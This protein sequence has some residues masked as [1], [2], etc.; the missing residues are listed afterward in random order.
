MYGGFTLDSAATVYIA[1]RGPSLQT[2]GATQNPLDAPG[3]RLYDAAGRDLLL[4]TS[5]GGQ[6]A[7]CLATNTT[8]IYYATVRGQA[9]DA[10]DTCISPRTLPAGVYTFTI[11]PTSTDPSG[12]VLFEVTFNP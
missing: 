12:E 1:V 2:L 10:R 3:L 5:G 11:V 4:N 9:L 8:A 7:T 6:V